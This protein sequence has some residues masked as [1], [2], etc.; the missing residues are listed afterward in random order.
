MLTT[1]QA[2]DD[3]RLRDRTAGW[4]VT[5]SITLTAFLL[6]FHNLA[7]P[8]GIM[9]DETYYA[10]DA[11]ALLNFGYEVNWPEAPTTRSR[12]ASRRAGRPAPPSSS[13][14]NSASG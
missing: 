5:L 4:V 1:L 7:E 10:K 8:H 14:H 6:R 2:L 3:G 12:P 11:W 13:T 9:F